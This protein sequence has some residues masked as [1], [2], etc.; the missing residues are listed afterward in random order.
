MPYDIKHETIPAKC[1][2]ANC[3]SKPTTLITAKYW[4][5]WF[6]TRL[7]PL[8]YSDN[9]VCDKHKQAQEDKM[10]AEMVH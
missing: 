3:E 10:L 4:G 8:R 5:Y 7:R 6:G 2:F 1:S 9:W